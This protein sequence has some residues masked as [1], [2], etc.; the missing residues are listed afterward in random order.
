MKNAISNVKDYLKKSKII[1]IFFILADYCYNII[2]ML[3]KLGIQ[4][5]LQLAKQKLKSITFH[6]R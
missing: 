5:K 3:K 6:E 2:T 4:L 1:L